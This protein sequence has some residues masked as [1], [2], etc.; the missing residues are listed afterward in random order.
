MT[1]QGVRHRSGLRERG[2]GRQIF[3][4]NLFQ[5]WLRQTSSIFSTQQLLTCMRNIYIQYVLPL[6]PVVNIFIFIF[7]FLFEKIFCYEHQQSGFRCLCCFFT[8]IVNYTVSC[9]DKMKHYAA[10][11]INLSKAFITVAHLDTV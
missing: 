2:M 3:E 5:S 8:L 6:E 9:M 7:F 1:L 4:E 10:V 11:S